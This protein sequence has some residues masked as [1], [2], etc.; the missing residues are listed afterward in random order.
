[1]PETVFE[2]TFDANDRNDHR[3]THPNPP[4]S[5]KSEAFDPAFDDNDYKN[6][7]CIEVNQQVEQPMEANDKEEPQYRGRNG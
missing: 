2:K 4:K 1:M 6:E 5:Q 7:E 3:A